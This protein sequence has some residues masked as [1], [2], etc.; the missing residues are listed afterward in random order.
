MSWGSAARGLQTATGF[1]T[2]IN[3]GAEFFNCVSSAISSALSWISIHQKPDNMLDAE[4]IIDE[5]NC[6]ELKA[7]IEGRMEECQTSSGCQES[8]ASVI[9]GSFNRVKE[10]QTKLDHLH[11]QFI[12]LGLQCA[13]QKFDKFVRPETSSF[14]N[15][16]EIFGRQKEDKMMLE[17]LGVPVQD[18]TGY[19]HKRSNRVE[20]LP[21]VGLGGVGKTTLAQKICNN[22]RVKA[23]FDMILWACVSDDFNSKRLAKEVIQSS[24]IET[25]FDN[26]DSLRSILKDIVESK[27][28][29]LVLD[30]IWDD[31][32]VDGGQEWQRFC[33][34]L[35]N[36]FQ[37]SMILITTRLH[38]VADKNTLVDIWLAEGFVEH[39]GSIPIVT[40]G[41][42]YFE[43]LVSRSFF[44]KVSVSSDK[45]VIHDLMH[46]MAQLVSRDECFIIRNVN[47]LRTIPPNVH[48]LSI[49]S[50]GNIRCHDLMGLC[51]YKKLRTLL[52]SKAYKQKEFVSVLSSWFK[53]LQHIRVLSYSLPMLEDIPESIRNLKLV[54]YSCFLS[55]HTFR[56]LPSSFCCL[57][58]LQT[59]DASTCVFKACLVTFES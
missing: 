42:Q 6:Y 3:T 40:I 35:S 48:H 53:E 31:V 7:K 36:A 44:Q 50:K 30:D 11:I 49:F 9:Q 32:M 21:I 39:T 18:N 58:N 23:H 47:D 45:Y 46:D 59:L 54:G 57:Y 52:C 41:Q 5:F 34:P 16:L 38:K 14:L 25:S 37:G 17:L 43:D 1:V 27:R 33:A 8:Y 56:I 26:L 20:V 12:D 28:F 24:K 2:G 51:G 13:T 15:E 4:D 10:I 55:Q 22:Q 19:K 29:L